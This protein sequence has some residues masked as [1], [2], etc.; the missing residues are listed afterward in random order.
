M[1]ICITKANNMTTKQIISDL[2]NGVKFGNHNTG[3]IFTKEGE[4]LICEYHNECKYTTF[5][6]IEKFARRILKFTKTG[7]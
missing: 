4:M 7:Y 3:F 6:T 2:Q 1:Y 5:Y